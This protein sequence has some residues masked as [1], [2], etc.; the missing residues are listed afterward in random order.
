[1]AL[2]TSTD[3]LSVG[4]GV[5]DDDHK[6]LGGMDA[7]K[8]LRAVSSLHRVV[9]FVDRFG[10]TFAAAWTKARVL[11]ASSRPGR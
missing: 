1:V 3:K 4:V 7:A 2:M 5:I 10:P 8:R 9:E 6:K 11:L